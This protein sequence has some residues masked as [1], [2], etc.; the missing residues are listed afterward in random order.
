MRRF[1][2]A[3]AAEARA[4]MQPS[5]V[6]GKWKRPLISK[7]QASEVRKQAMLNGTFGSWNPGQGGWLPE[8]DPK[9]KL[10]VMKPP[11]QHKHFRTREERVAKIQKAMDAMPQKLAEMKKVQKAAR[12]LKGL[13]KFL[14]E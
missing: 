1:L 7:R 2:K 4:M 13:E 11:K 3:S 6:D 9:P 12:P 8:W 10:L 5:C 14:A